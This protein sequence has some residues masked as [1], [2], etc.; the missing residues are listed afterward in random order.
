MV[1]ATLQH[2]HRFTVKCRRQL[3]HIFKEIPFNAGRIQIVVSLFFCFC[4]CFRSLLHLSEQVVTS[5]QFRSHFLRHVKRRSQ[6]TQILASF[7][8]PLSK[9]VLTEDW[10]WFFS[11]MMT[12]LHLKFIHITCHSSSKHFFFS[13]SRE[14]FFFFKKNCCKI[15]AFSFNLL[16]KMPKKANW[17]QANLN[18]YGLRVACKPF[19][20]WCLYPQQSSKIKN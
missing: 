4:L 3:P 18:F 5:A 2:H 11:A 1:A 20:Q 15:A 9:T 6:T 7:W 16:P 19:T 14:G 10:R 12:L 17:M 8:T 13:E